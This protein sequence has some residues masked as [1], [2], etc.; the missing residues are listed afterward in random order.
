[1]PAVTEFIPL[2]FAEA[3]GVE[4]AKSKGVSSLEELR[5]L[6]ASELIADFRPNND[7]SAVVDGWFL[8]EPMDAVFEKG[9][10]NDVPTMVGLTAD[11][12]RS[13]ITTLAEFTEQA[14]E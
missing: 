14:R 10:Q 7:Y 11:D 8:P 2:D 5:A 13:R 9:Q 4:F 1:M 12:G 6:P 3:K